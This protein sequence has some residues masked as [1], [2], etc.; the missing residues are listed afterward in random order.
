MNHQAVVAVGK[1]ETVAHLGH[2]HSQHR[3]V[4]I[5]QH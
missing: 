3:T 5:I 4:E 2:D 1:G